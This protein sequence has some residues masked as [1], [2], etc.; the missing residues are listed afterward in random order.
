ML[1]VYYFISKC[2][3]N[4]LNL[5]CNIMHDGQFGKLPIDTLRTLDF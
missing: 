5:I 1:F 4:F 2:A 3:F